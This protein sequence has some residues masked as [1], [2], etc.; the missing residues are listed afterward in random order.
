MSVRSGSTRN[1][2]WRSIIVS[3]TRLYGSDRPNHTVFYVFLLSKKEEVQK[4]TNI[5]IL[6]LGASEPR[7][8]R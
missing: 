5:D 4:V 6:F 2:P 8:V 7:E 3:W 1:S